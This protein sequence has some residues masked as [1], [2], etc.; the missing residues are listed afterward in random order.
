MR[1]MG[2]PDISHSVAPSLRILSSLSIAFIIPVEV[3]LTG[4]C[5][6]NSKPDLRLYCSH[7]ALIVGLHKIE[8]SRELLLDRIEKFLKKGQCQVVQRN[9]AG[10]ARLD[11]QRHYFCPDR[12]AKNILQAV[13]LSVLLRIDH[14]GLLVQV[15]KSQPALQHLLSKMMV[16]DNTIFVLFFCGKS[17]EKHYQN[18]YQRQVYSNFHS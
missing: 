4:G 7:P 6:K 13:Q 12:Q 5:R 2:I 11:D 10:Y 16:F 8:R 18:S 3:K 9:Q 1:P 14:I 15:L 17:P